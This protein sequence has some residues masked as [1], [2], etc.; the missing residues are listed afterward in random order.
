MV[1][2]LQQQKALRP[3]FSG[4]R[5]PLENGTRQGARRETSAVSATYS[6]ERDD[7]AELVCDVRELGPDH[8]GTRRSPD[9]MPKGGF[10]AQEPGTGSPTRRPGLARTGGSAA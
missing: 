2:S 10:L 7:P 8:A 1:S 3:E 4:N 9:R 6:T 5:A